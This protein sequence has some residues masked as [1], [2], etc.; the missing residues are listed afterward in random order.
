[1]SLLLGSD[2]RDG[3]KVGQS[4]VRSHWRSRSTLEASVFVPRRA[5]PGESFFVTRDFLSLLEFTRFAVSLQRGGWPNP[6]L[7]RTK[8]GLNTDQKT[9]SDRRIRVSSVFHP[10]LRRRF[11]RA[12]SVPRLPNDNGA[13]QTSKGSVRSVSAAG[14]SPTGVRPNHRFLNFARHISAASVLREVTHV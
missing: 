13:R 10:W 6:F 12:S 1:M 5:K 11:G 3:R 4:K 2:L 7:P 14:R 9:I 8:H